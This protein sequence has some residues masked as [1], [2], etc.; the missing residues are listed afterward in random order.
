MREDIRI[1]VSLRSYGKNMSGPIRVY[2]RMN[3]DL[4]SEK[5]MLAEHFPIFGDPL[6]PDFVLFWG[7]LPTLLDPRTGIKS[8]GG[9][10][11]VVVLPSTVQ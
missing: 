9:S 8:L 11:P 3:E 6:P 4:R 1:D 5:V 2:P 10:F 7:V